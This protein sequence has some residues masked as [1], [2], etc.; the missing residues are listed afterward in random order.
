MAKSKDLSSSLEDYLEEIYKQV[1]INKV[2]RCKDI[3]A[4]LNV[5]RA[6]V[7]GALKLLSER[8]MINYDPYQF[9]TLTERGEEFAKKI[10][11]RHQIIKNFFIDVLSI[12]NDLADESACKME[13][14]ISGKVIDS[15]L[16]FANFMK[17]KMNE[18]TDWFN[19]FNSFCETELKRKEKKEDDTPSE[20]KSNITIGRGYCH[21]YGS[22]KRLTDLQP[23]AFGIIKKIGGNGAI[24][25]RLLDMG[26]TRNTKIKIERVAPLGD[27]IE[28]TVKGYNLAIR[29]EEARLIEIEEN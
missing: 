3:A 6:S 4:S 2:A 19:E 23:G 10:D 5:T 28:I 11:R 17:K 16:L 29:K 9:I 21:R 18:T 27:P 24:R 26:I 25:Q 22:V 14:A 8:G 1:R 12:D 15:L 13:H 20:S 7:T